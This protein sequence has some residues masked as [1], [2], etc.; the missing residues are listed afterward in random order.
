MSSTQS[1]IVHDID[2]TGSDLPPRGSSETTPPSES[3]QGAPVNDATSPD[4]ALTAEQAEDRW[5]RAVADLDNLRKRYAREVEYL[6][7][8]ERAAVAAQFLPV[9]DNLELAL[10]HADSDPASIIDGVYAVRDQAI[11][12]LARLGYVRREQAG[13][14]FDPAAHEVVSVV[15]DVDVAPGTVVQVLRPGYG[16]ADRQLRPVAVTVARQP[17]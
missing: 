1:S 13:V 16:D 5:R 17:E 6:R 15:D 14:P 10:A 3:S 7:E 4:S 8:N 12:V 2:R 9:L 11:A